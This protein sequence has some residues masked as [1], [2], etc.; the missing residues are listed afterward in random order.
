MPKTKKKIYLQAELKKVEDKLMFVAS[1]ET[2]DRHGDVIP[3]DSWDLKNYRKNPVL[4]INHDYSVE[5]IVGKAGSL[6]LDLDTKQLTFEPIFHELTQTSSEAKAM[7]EGG[8]LSTVS[9]GFMPIW[10][11]KDGDKIKYELLE[12][13]FVP[14]PANPSAE[15]LKALEGEA[16]DDETKEKIEDFAKED[17]EEVDAG[18]VEE[19]VV[20]ADETDEVPAE[21]PEKN[22]DENASEVIDTDDQFKRLVLDA[23]AGVVSCS[24]AFLKLRIHQQA[25]VGNETDKGRGP[26]STSKAARK[27][28]LEVRMLQRVAKHINHALSEINQIQ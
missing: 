10:P 14:V 28:P 16:V 25:A 1:D 22:D 7:V 5:S 21:V 6:N 27:R 24:V 20:E 3:I 23:D 17:G 26:Q 8:Y 18:E 19:P 13:S 11:K 2:L 12:I 9:V 4:L 15:R